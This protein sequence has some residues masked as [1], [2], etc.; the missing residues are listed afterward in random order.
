MDVHR[1]VLATAE[2]AAD[3]GQRQPDLVGSETEGR[4]DLALVDVQPL[5]RD[6]E[7]DAADLVRHGEPGLRAEERLVLH[8]DLVVADDRHDIGVVG[9]GVHVADPDLEVADEVALRVQLRGLSTQLGDVTGQVAVQVEPRA[10]APSERRHR[11][12]HVVVDDDLLR[13]LPRDLGVVGGDQRHRLA[14]V[15]HDVDRQHRLVGAS[16]P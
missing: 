2:R 3:A 12:E 7:V 5:G 4:A 16:R 8:P 13:R 9:A 15:A 14:L 11:L 1:Q 6:V 10:P